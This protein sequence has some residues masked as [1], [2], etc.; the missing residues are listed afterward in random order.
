MNGNYKQKHLQCNCQRYNPY[1]LLQYSYLFSNAY[2]YKRSFR[3]YMP[4]FLNLN[5]VFITLIVLQI[6]ITDMDKGNKPIDIYLDMSKAF[7]ILD[8]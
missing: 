4:H 2:N 6:C 3:H 1:V 8:H 7:D 5:V